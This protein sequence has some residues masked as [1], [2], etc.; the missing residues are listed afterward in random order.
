MPGKDIGLKDNPL[1]FRFSPDEKLMYIIAQSQINFS[2]VLEVH[3][4]DAG[5][6]LNRFTTI[7]SAMGNARFN[8]LAPFNS[9]RVSLTGATDT[10]IDFGYL[11]MPGKRLQAL[12]F[13]TINSSTQQANDLGFPKWV[14]FNFNE[15]RTYNYAD[16][17]FRKDALYQ[18]RNTDEVLNYDEDGQL[19]F[20]SNGKAY[21]L[22]AKQR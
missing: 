17:R 13:N 14:T 16:G 7:G 15:Q 20:T 3:D 18:F 19:Y 22:N 21:L 2:F 4:I 9:L 6:K 10:D 5:A 1:H 8:V 11:P 12:L